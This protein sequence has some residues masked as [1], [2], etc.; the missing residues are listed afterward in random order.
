[1]LD[2][3][4]ELLKKEQMKA[5]IGQRETLK[6]MQVMHGNIP[7]MF[8]FWTDPV[9]NLLLPKSSIVY[10]LLYQ[11]VA[12]L[13]VVPTWDIG[14][15]SGLIKTTYKLLC[16]WGRPHLVMNRGLLRCQGSNHF[17]HS[18]A[19]LDWN[20]EFWLVKRG[21]V[22]F[23]IQSEWI[24]SWSHQLRVKHWTKVRWYLVY[25]LITYN[26]SGD[27]QIWIKIAKC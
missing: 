22:T 7:Y 16:L 2:C 1:M 26:Q 5:D 13:I 24:F 14:I 20:K 8:D 3:T 19:T 21:H 12:I 6:I 23:N 9:V 4:I 18:I 10:P 11:N 15:E 17:L 27:Q 25:P